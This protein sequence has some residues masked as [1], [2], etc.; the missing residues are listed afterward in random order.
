MGM[1]IRTI[2]SCSV[3]E[4]ALASGLSS[5]LPDEAAL[6]RQQVGAGKLDKDTID[7]IFDEDGSLSAMW[8]LEAKRAQLET[9]RFLSNQ[10]SMPFMPTCTPVPV[11]TP[12]PSIGRTTLVPTT[13]G[14]FPPSFTEK[15]TVPPISGQTPAPFPSQNN[16]DCLEGTAL[17]AYLTALLSQV[18][19]EEILLDEATPQGQALAAML[20]DPFVEQNACSSDTLDQR[21]GLIT[22]YYST[23]GDEWSTQTSWLTDTDECTWFGVICDDADSRATNLTLGTL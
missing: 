11:E 4:H 16:T 20:S 5:G 15:G 17:D 6:A 22:F 9:R 13:R 19:A 7:A 21:Y 1:L 10:G 23:G 12:A 18:T 14:T 8:E 2:I 3:L